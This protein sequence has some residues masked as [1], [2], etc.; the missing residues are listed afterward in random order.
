MYYTILLNQ[1]FINLFN[2]YSSCNV[3]LVM[4]KDIKIVR[5]FRKQK[6]LKTQDPIAPDAECDPLKQ[7]HVVV[8]PTTCDPRTQESDAVRVA[9]PN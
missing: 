7:N 1:L 9:G 8:S 5:S 3:V 2:Q 4:V 6:L